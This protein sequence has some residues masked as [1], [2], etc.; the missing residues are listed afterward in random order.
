MVKFGIKGITNNM[1]HEFTALIEEH[2]KP[3]LLLLSSITAYSKQHG[4]AVTSAYGHGRT[5]LWDG[6][7]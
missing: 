6:S 2:L 3:L 1:P 7:L 4:K 5:E